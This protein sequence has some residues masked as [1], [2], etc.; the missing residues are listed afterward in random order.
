MK[1]QFHETTAEGKPLPG[2]GKIIEGIDALEIVNHMRK[3]TVL[4]AAVSPCGY[5]LSQLGMLGRIAPPLP[6]PPE[7]AAPEFLSRMA[8]SGRISFV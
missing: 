5:M 2:T 1:I 8:S 7:H 6:E 3:Q 4:S